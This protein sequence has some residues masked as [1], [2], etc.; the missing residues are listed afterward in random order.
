MGKSLNL[1]I[2]EIVI[3]NEMHGVSQG[4][5]EQYFEKVLHRI[6]TCIQYW[7]SNV[8]VYTLFGI[9]LLGFMLT[10]MGFGTGKDV[11]ISPC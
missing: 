9:S 11:V 2:Y 8:Y 6:C 10:P 1:E 5:R 3:V 4:R 7:P